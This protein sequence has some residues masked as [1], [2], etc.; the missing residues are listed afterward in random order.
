MVTTIVNL[1]KDQYLQVH[2]ERNQLSKEVGKFRDRVAVF[3]ARKAK[4]TY[5]DLRPSGALGNSVGRFTFSKFDC[6]DSFLD[7][8]NYVETRKIG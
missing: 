6:N 4:L 5:D 3:E 7:L 1:H 8:I 2:V